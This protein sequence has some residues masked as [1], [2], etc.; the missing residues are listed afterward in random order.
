MR[1]ALSVTRHYSLED[2]ICHWALCLRT[3]IGTRIYQIV[4]QPT[5]FVY[6]HRKNVDPEDSAGF[7]ESIFVSEIHSEHIGAVKEFLKRFPIRN[8]LSTWES[9]D[10]ALEAIGRLQEGGFLDESAYYSVYDRLYSI[11]YE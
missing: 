2:D 6:Q 1:A 7:I 10:W 5:S 3:S 9:R 4:G 11:C 8:D